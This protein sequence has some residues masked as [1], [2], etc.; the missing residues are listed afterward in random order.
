MLFLPRL[1]APVLASLV[2]VALAA[3]PALAAPAIDDGLALSAAAETLPADPE[4]KD[5]VPVALGT[6]GAI[7]VAGVI[8]TL[9]YLYRR[10]A[11][12][13]EHYADGFT[14]HDTR[15]HPAY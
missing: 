4:N 2:L 6:L 3:G 9:G 15:D 1:I 14:P 10:Q 5:L 12:H 13:T 8:V 11:G 7:G